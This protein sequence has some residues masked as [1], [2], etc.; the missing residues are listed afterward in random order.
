MN[1]NETKALEYAGRL[2]DTGRAVLDAAESKVDAIPIDPNVNWARDP[3]VVGLAILCRTV[4]NFNAAMSLVH[5]GHVLEGRVLVRLMYENL[6]WMGALRERRSDF[7][8]DMIENERFNQKALAQL[9]MKMTGKYGADVNS[10]CALTLRS[11]ITELEK[12]AATKLRTDKIAASGAVE[13]AYVE[14]QRFSLDAAHC[15]VTA[16]GRH[17]FRENAGNVVNRVVSVQAK[18]LPDETLSTILHACR[19]LMGVVVGANELLEGTAAN[20]AI[21]AIVREFERN[22]WTVVN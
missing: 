14:Y 4:S 8:Q 3:K 17:L 9:T 2:L 10:E 6:L 21:N 7:V 13:T 5:Q 22:G 12:K 15:S 20:T 19:A 16:L 11:I 18:T 1:A